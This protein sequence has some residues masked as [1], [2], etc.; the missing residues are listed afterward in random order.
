MAARLV[1]ARATCSWKPQRSDN[2]RLCSSSSH[3]ASP[4]A[5]VRAAP[6][7]LSAWAKISSLPSCRASTIARSPHS[8]ALAFCDAS[9]ASC[10][11]L[12]K[13]IASS[14]LAPSGSSA[15]TA[16]YPVQAR[17]RTHGIARSPGVAIRAPD[18]E[19]ITLDI[20]RFLDLAGQEALV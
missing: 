18:D 8:M 11:M 9:I 2:C 3:P 14:S 13:A 4:V 7:L 6:T 5:T 10:A 15:A 1:Y 19:R 20:D 17:Q 16:P 12:L